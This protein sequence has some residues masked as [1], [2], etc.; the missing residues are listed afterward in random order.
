[1]MQIRAEIGIQNT[2]KIKKKLNYSYRV[3]VI[4]PQNIAR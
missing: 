1:M 3:S 2:K 4:K